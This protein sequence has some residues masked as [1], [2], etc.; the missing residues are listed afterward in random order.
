M[1]ECPAII[2]AL[3]REVKH[4]VRG[5]QEHRL[6][7]KIVVY[8]N[9][10]GVVACAGMGSARATLAV[11]AAL[12]LRPAV[13]TL[14]SAGLAGA[15]DPSLRVGEIVRAGVVVDTQSGERFSDSEFQQT[16]ASAPSIASVAEKRRLFDSYRASA[17]DMEAATVARM[18]RAY[19]LGFHAIKAISDEATFELQEL[20]R[21]ATHDGQFREAGF[22]AYSAVRPQMWPK[23]FE[24][25]VNSKRAV[26]ALT[27]ELESRL[28]WYRQKG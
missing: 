25:A 8:S 16:L 26:D 18:A 14:F 3:P 20:A 13:T 6:P 2:A 17:V 27:A 1:R 23:L 24:L 10:L 22:A 4:L 7:G 11:Q 19:G 21:F 5:W 12:S 9:D 15:C 28:D